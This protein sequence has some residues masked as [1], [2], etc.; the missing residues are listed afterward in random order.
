MVDQLAGSNAQ[1]EI[2]RQIS[3]ASG[4][5]STAAVIVSPADVSISAVFANLEQLERRFAEL[6]SRISMRSINAARD[7][8][9]VYG[10]TPADR[11]ADLLA[12]L[13]DNPAASTIIN[14]RATRFLIV[15]RSPEA[16]QLQ[17]LDILESHDWQSVYT[18]KT[19]IASAQ[20]ERDVAAGLEKDLRL[21]LPVI[22]ATT[23][24]A[25]FL[26]FGY[27]RALLLPLFASI[28]S[29]LVTFALFSATV[30]TINLITLLALP[31]V[32]IVGLANSCHFLARSA[33]DLSSREDVDEAV[34]V[35][36]QRVGP[37]FFFSTLTT[38]IALA[39]LGLNELPPIASLGLLS[40]GSLLIVF[41]L[42]LLAA[43]LSLRWYL[44]GSGPSWQ[45]SRLF[46]ALS[47]WLGRRRVH[48]SAVLVLAMIAGAASLPL[49]NVKSEPRA[50]FPD[51]APFS[52]ALQLFESEF[53]LFSPLQVLVLADGAD[54]LVALRG[55]GAMRDSLAEHAGIRQV[56]M[57]PAA[58]RADA[59]VLTALL[60]GEDDLAAVRS[61]I[62]N[63]VLGEG[64]TVIYSN[65]SLVYGDI[66]RQAMASLLRSLGWSV[67]LIF[68][69]I[70]L[71]FRS[72]R[73]MFSAMLANAVPLMLVCGAVWLV[74]SPLNLVTVFVF[75]VALGVIVDDSIH[76][77]FWRAAGD[78]ISGSSIEFSVILST[79]I[80]CLGLLLCQ[81]SDFP[82][83]RLFA[84]YCAL[85]LVGAVVS[86]LSVLPLMLGSSRL[87]DASA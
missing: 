70:L 62:D 8:L 56:S 32:L 25:V 71:V 1:L 59:Y 76:L 52:S 45:A 24:V 18:L 38:S 23:L 65:A 20:L 21:L 50:F 83:T 51:D 19:V 72:A 28:A 4:A 44:Q 48:I 42:V 27:W 41:L 6:D 85:A 74:G 54:P 66:D 86:N 37:P 36:L 16:L 30:V 73:A 7:Q 80:L 81:L 60:A 15:V 87:R 31:V 9:F 47:R 61:Q 35:T 2:A 78:S 67:A 14:K 82:T 40:A 10:L 39:S 34:R 64:V 53:Y 55:A 77:L 12:V 58:G 68:G 33:A 75:L 84:V 5:A 79:I 26:A 46:G 63:A 29:T 3:A 69:S 49:L 13:R 11:V 57:E 17:A 43:P 22:V